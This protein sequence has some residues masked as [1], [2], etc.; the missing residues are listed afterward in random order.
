MS[1]EANT[2]KRERQ[3]AVLYFEAGNSVAFKELAARI[4]SE[5]GRT[6]LVWSDRWSGTENLLMEAR[7]VVIQKDCA[8]AEAICAAYRQYAHDVEIHFVNTEG[9]FEEEDGETPDEDEPARV[10]DENPEIN[11]A[12]Q[13]DA[14]SDEG[15]SGSDPVAP[16][17]DPV[18]E[19]QDDSEPP[20]AAEPP[21]TSS[22]VSDRLED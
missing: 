15:D 22:A 18:P 21:D 20:G 19:V 6:T 10:A 9:E 2:V 8:N 17:G 7:A 11:T 5:G 14:G 4:R 13:E 12:V 3:H 16:V 1:D